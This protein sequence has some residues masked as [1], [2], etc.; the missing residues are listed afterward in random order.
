[1]RSACDGNAVVQ[2]PDPTRASRF[3]CRSA[4]ELAGQYRLAIAPAT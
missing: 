1:M 4:A 2:L 3:A